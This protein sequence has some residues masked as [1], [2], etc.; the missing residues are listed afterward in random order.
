MPL[1]ERITNQPIDLPALVA[2]YDPRFVTL[3]S[4]HSA[5]EM[6]GQR[7]IIPRTGRLRDVAVWIG[8]SSGNIAAAVYDTT[9]TTRNRLATSGSVAAGGGGWQIVFDPDIAVTAGDQIDLA[10]AADNATVTFG[11]FSSAVSSGIADLPTGFVVAPLGGFN[12]IMWS[13][14]SS[15]P[16]PSTLGE[17]SMGNSNAGPFVM[18]RIS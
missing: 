10:V 4:G 17:G 2:P 18:A 13:A 11:R 12:K 16:P 5:N 6:R 15:F 3:A 14:T 9:G 1:T 7:V 8:T